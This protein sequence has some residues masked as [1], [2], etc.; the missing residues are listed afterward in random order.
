[1]A[2]GSFRKRGDKWELSVD[3]GKVPDGKGGMKRL[4]KYKT[5]QAKGPRE[6]EKKLTDFVAE[7]TSD[8]YFEPEKMPFVDFVMNEW[9][10]KY[11]EKHLSPKT[12]D[13][14]MIYI[15]NRII[16]AF[17]HFRIDQVK[18]MH[19]ISFLDNLSED[20]MRN[21]GKEGKLSSATIQY[22]HRILRNIFKRAVDWRL[23]K[24]SPAENV[25]KPKITTKE[26]AVYDENQA[27]D[28]MKA[29]E[30]EQIQWQ[31]FIKL[32]ITTGL[33][34][35]ELL[36]LELKHLDLEKRVISVRQG[37]TYTKEHGFVIGELKTSGSKRNVSIPVSLIP[38]IK[39]LKSR[40]QHERM[41]ADELWNDGDTFLL[42]SDWSG[43]P[44]HP[45]SV[46]T[47]WKRFIKRRG[48]D[49][50][51]FHALRHTSATLLINK[52]VHAKTI[53]SRL[54]HAD[55]KTTMNIYGHA[56]ESADQSAANEFDNLFQPKVNSD[57]K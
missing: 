6:A 31:V 45:S 4:R 49:Y 46:N 18:P 5:V 36:G 13:T 17:Q 24:E 55:I 54:G 14:H 33:R 57:E 1:M 37:L 25:K 56:L 7:V 32:A 9:K 2:R 41:A 29:L 47:W 16:P 3:L 22:Y 12:Y 48:L 51:N 23:I 26:V 8:N 39:K 44:L 19:V 53:S 35:S 11:A 28:L 30:N 10:P 34:R 38:L 43:K 40:K 50:I 15:R 42:F 21:D 52:G 27:A 20:G